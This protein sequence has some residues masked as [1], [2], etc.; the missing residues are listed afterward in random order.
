MTEGATRNRHIVSFL[1]SDWRVVR[2]AQ[3]WLKRLSGKRME[4]AMQYRADQDVDELQR[5]WADLLK[6]APEQIKPQRKSNSGQLSGRNFRS[7]HGLL[8]V[9]TTDTYLRARLEAWID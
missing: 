7:V 6:I 5:Y 1:N 8:T 3:R 4:Y 9:R 2:L